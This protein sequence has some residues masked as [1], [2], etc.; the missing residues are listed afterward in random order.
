[1]PGVAPEAAPLAG[2]VAGWLGG[3]PGWASDADEAG[4]PAPD[5][6]VWYRS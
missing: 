4:R 1:L 6:V 3:F 2:R 5:L